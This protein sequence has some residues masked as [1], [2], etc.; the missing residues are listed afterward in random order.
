MKIQWG[1]E[2]DEN[3]SFFHDTVNRKRRKLA[4]RGVMRD[5]LWIGEP[6]LVKDPF[7]DFYQ[8]LSKRQRG[9]KLKTQSSHFHTHFVS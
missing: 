1:V 2:G 9:R 6:M 4:I 3:T 8:S 7:Q 5:E